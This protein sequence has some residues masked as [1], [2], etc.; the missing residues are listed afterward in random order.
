MRILLRAAATTCLLAAVLGA[1]SS[2]GPCAGTQGRKQVFFGGQPSCAL[3]G[4]AFQLVGDPVRGTPQAP[5]LTTGACEIKKPLLETE[6]GACPEGM[7][8]L[9]IPHHRNAESHGDCGLL[10]LCLAPSLPTGSDFG[11][12]YFQSGGAPDVPNP[13]KA[14]RAP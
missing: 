14:P 3:F 2:D 7:R 6:A 11:G 12:A 13:Y 1:C 5:S 9:A 8:K 4:G 10:V